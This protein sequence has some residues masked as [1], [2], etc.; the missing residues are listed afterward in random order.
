MK[1]IAIYLLLPILSAALATVGVILGGIGL[2][3][4]CGIGGCT[5]DA[6]YR[7]IFIIASIIAMLHFLIATV[8]SRNIKQSLK[9]LGVY[10]LLIFIAIQLLLR[11]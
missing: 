5:D 3:I 6:Y 9:S 11:I 8:I 10:F 2:G 4:S 7:P 1:R